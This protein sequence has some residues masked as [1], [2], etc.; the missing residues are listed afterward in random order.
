MSILTHSFINTYV[1]SI[2]SSPQDAFINGGL[3]GFINFAICYLLTRNNWSP[4]LYL[5]FKLTDILIY[6]VLYLSW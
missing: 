5:K 1:L 4:I 2:Y 6:A 3:V